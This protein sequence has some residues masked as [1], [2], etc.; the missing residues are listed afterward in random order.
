MI[1]QINT[2]KYN[3][4]YV[5]QSLNCHL[6]PIHTDND[7]R[8]NKAYTEQEKEINILEVFFRY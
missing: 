1:K 4:K 8:V 7:K 5:K 2:N 3:K 6:Y